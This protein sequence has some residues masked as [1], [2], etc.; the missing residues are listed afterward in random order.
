M[1]VAFRAVGADP[2]LIELEPWEIMRDW[3]I[4]REE[5]IPRIALGALVFIIEFPLLDF[6]ERQITQMMT[7]RGVP[8]TENQGVAVLWKGLNGIPYTLDRIIMKV[9]F[10]AYVVILGPILEEWLFRERLQEKTMTL[11]WG[12]SDHILNRIVRVLING[13]LFGAVHWIE[14]VGWAAVPVFLVTMTIGIIY[15]ILKEITGDIISSSTAHML[16]NGAA[17]TLFLLE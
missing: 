17:M 14:V 13:V 1:N 6:A 2:T 10:L 16:H 4:M 3:E 15:A 11:A 8:F 5:I 12:D 7:K 9:A